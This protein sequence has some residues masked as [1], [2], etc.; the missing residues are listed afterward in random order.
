[1]LYSM[2]MEQVQ[3]TLMWRNLILQ[4]RPDLFNNSLC[5]NKLYSKRIS[6]TGRFILYYLNIITGTS[7]SLW[8]LIFLILPPGICL[9]I[10]IIY[11]LNQ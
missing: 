9:F 2:Q 1:M 5:Y 11:Q 8:W 7:S 6:N 10:Y 4:V 3:D